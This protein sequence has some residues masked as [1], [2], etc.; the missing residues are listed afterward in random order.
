MTQ[1][2]IEDKAEFNRLSERIGRVE[3]KT[4]AA[5]GVVSVVVAYLTTKLTGH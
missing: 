2:S 5:G 3:R 1:H 4:W